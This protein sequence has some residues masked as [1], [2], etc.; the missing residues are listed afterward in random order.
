MTSSSTPIATTPTDRLELLAVLRERVE[1]QQ[2]EDEQHHARRDRQQGAAVDRPAQRRPRADHAGGDRGEDQDRLQPLAED[3]QRGV[4]DR[5]R[6]AGSVAGYRPGVVELF[7]EVEARLADLAQRRVAGDQLGQPRVAVCAVPDQPL[8]LERQLRVEGPQLQLGPEL[9]EAVGGEPRLLGLL[10]PAGA[11]RRFELVEGDVDEFVVGFVARLASTPRARS[12][13]V[14]AARVARRVDLLLGGDRDALLGVVDVVAQ[15]R[16]GGLDPLHR[17]WVA[18]EQDRLEVGEG[19]FD[20]VHEG[21]RLLDLER[22]RHPPVGGALVVLLRDQVE[23]AGQLARPVDLLVGRQRRRREALEVGFGP[24]A[25]SFETGR[26][27]PAPAAA[28]AAKSRPVARALRRAALL[29]VLGGDRQPVAGGDRGGFGEAA[30]EAALGCLRRFVEVGDEPGLE[31]VEQ[32]LFDLR[33]RLARRDF[34]GGERVDRSGRV[35]ARA[36]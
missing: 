23:E 33:P 8:D 24:L 15:L 13:R 19:G 16:E 28:R 27:S 18:L 2:G 17:R 5:R 10:V 6:R 7:V 32:V 26:S 20:A 22:D 29:A 12:A 25:G 4:G 14:S 3:D 9:E 21:D 35:D 31:G 1:Q 11:G 34:A 30:A 36:G